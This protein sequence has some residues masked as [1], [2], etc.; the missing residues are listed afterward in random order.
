MP[1]I[2]V[3][4]MLALLSAGAW[5]QNDPGIMADPI[6]LTDQANAYFRGNGVPQSDQRAAELYQQAAAMG[7]ARA[8]HNLGFMYA[9]GR[10]VAQD[11]FHAIDL[12]RAAMAHTYIPAV[13]SLGIA[14]AEGR[15]VS[16]EPKTAYMLL[17]RS[18][19]AGDKRAADY[20]VQTK[21]R[22]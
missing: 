7:Y 21:L 5:A 2:I 20:L 15:G 13:T 10:G 14:Y 9:E 17:K 19:D 1:R 8:M 4:L 16:V 22:P 6:A 3:G 18:A 12:Y 11:E